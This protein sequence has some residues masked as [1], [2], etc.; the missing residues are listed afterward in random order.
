MPGALGDQ[1]TRLGAH[2]EK[3]TPMSALGGA[4]VVHDRRTLFLRTRL[5]WGI[6]EDLGGCLSYSQRTRL[7]RGDG[8]PPGC[9]TLLGPTLLGAE[10]KSLRSLTAESEEGERDTNRSPRG[11]KA[12]GTLPSSPLSK[13]TSGVGL[14]LSELQRFRYIRLPH[15]ASRLR[16]SDA[17][18]RRPGVPGGSPAIGPGVSPQNKHVRPI[19]T[20]TTCTH[21]SAF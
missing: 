2:D 19:S 8:L 16:G 10:T 7:G 18:P 21:S 14:G 1:N 5:G 17:G 4:A 12:P 20:Y 6:E 3:A 9:P 15:P 11:L 13:S